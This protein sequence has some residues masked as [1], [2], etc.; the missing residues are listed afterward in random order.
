MLVSDTHC[1]CFDCVEILLATLSIH[2]SCPWEVCGL[3]V[4]CVV[5][6]VLV[7]RAL[8]ASPPF[9]WTLFDV[10]TPLINSHSKIELNFSSCSA[11]CVVCVV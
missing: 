10:I 3:R 5:F 6:L 7:H 8:S 2:T 11:L 9:P 4:E 1:D